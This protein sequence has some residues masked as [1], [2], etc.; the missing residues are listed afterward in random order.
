MDP[1]VQVWGHFCMGSHHHRRCPS[2]PHSHPASQMLC[3]SHLSLT[4]KP[5]RSWGSN[6]PPA[7]LCS[8]PTR[9][10]NTTL[11]T[12][13]N[14]IKFWSAK[15]GEKTT[16]SSP[17]WFSTFNITKH[18]LSKSHCVLTSFDRPTSPFLPLSFLFL[19]PG[20]HLHHTLSK[21]HEWLQLF[22]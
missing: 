1:W 10:I 8:S 18:K 16:L 15:H 3:L 5:L 14:E 6:Q 2:S 11:M 7:P 4:V 17:S 13:V 19:L 20:S 9:K 12:T 21:I 22:S